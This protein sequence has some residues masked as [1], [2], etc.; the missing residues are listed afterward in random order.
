MTSQNP[1]AEE[2]GEFVVEPTVYR[3]VW[4][5][6]DPYHGLVVRVLSLPLGTLLELAP[7]VD[8]LSQLRAEDLTIEQVPEVLKPFQVISRYL[9][10]W[11]LTELVG[12]AKRPVP[13]TFEGLLSQKVEFVRAVI[14]AWMAAS[15]SI[16]DPL[17]PTSSP[18]STRDLDLEASLDMQ[19]LPEPSGVPG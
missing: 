17:G 8:A 16:P 19:A 2:D 13:A 1:Y 10:S 14:N 7:L 5:E 4:P 3:L 9:V 15:G 12:G 18:G 6:G 11:N